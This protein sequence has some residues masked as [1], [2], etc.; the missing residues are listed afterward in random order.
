MALMRRPG[1]RTQGFGANKPVLKNCVE[2]GR[3]FSPTRGEKICRDCRLKEEE[4]ERQVMSYV[5]D[6]PG[7]SIGEAVRGSGVPEKIV[8]RMAREG[9][10]VT[11][12]FATNVTYPCTR[13]GKPITGGTYCTDCLQALRS[14]TKKAAEAM[15]IRVRETKKM[16]T[17]D[18]LNAEAKRE[19]D[20][21][22]RVIERH[23]SKGM[24]DLINRSKNRT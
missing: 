17:I 15:N 12:G 22:N 10:F 11:Q 4:L 16:S 8:K 3:I 18:R 2:C 1:L 24:Q 9:M 5:R 7:I 19:V 20:S 6:H 14:E 13:C 21:E 23:F